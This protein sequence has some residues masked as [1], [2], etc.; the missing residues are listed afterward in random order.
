MMMVVV[1]SHRWD[2]T[3]HRFV[4]ESKDLTFRRRGLLK[5]VWEEED[6]APL[7]DLMMSC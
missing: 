2:Q 6:M 4:D 5:I 7:A 1:A 3:V